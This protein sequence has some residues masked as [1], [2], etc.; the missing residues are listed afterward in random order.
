MIEFTAEVSGKY[1]LVDHSLSRSLDKGT[2]AELIVEGQGQPELYQPISVI[3][4]CQ[5]VCGKLVSRKGCSDI[6][7]LD[8]PREELV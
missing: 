1:L 5:T 4:T 7:C 3:E 2:L 8:I 6:I